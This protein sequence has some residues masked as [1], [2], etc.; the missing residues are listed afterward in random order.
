MIVRNEAI[1]IRREGLKLEIEIELRYIQKCKLVEENECFQIKQNNI[2]LK[3]L[4]DS[5]YKS[6]FILPEILV[7]VKIINNLIS[8]IKK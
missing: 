6:V 1:F 3:T 4:N 8:N 2:S 5:Y 7:C